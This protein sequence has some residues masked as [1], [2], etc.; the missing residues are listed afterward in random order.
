MESYIQV[1]PNEFK[2]TSVIKQLEGWTIE[3]TGNGQVEIEE[4][5]RQ[6]DT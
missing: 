4:D 2:S 6:F 1:V 3:E 5:F